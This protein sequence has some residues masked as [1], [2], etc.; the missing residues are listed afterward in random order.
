[1]CT[2][3]HVEA[4]VDTDLF[5]KDA[6]LVHGVRPSA[7]LGKAIAAAI[8]DPDP[9]NIRT[10]MHARIDEWGTVGKGDV[11]LLRH[12]AGYVHGRID[13]LFDQVN[14]LVGDGPFAIFLRFE[15]V[16]ETRRS[17]KLRSSGTAS[18][19]FV[20]DVSCSL[21]WTGTNILWCSS[22]IL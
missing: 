8:A 12:G 15:V 16:A 21:T 1:M 6:C 4:L 11:V 19:I 2:A 17:W 14:R 7:K 3:H 20:R 10:A 9:G 5:G 22:H 18:I 13:A